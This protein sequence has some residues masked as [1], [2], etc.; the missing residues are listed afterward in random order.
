MGPRR[1]AV[2]ASGGGSNFQAILDAHQRRELELAPVCLVSDRDGIGALA[3]AER[4]GL[5]LA[6]FGRSTWRGEAKAVQDLLSFLREHSVELIAL[7]GFLRMLPAALLAAYPDRILNIHPALLPAFGGKGMYG[8]RVHEAVWHAGCRVSGA[9]V[10]LVNERYDEG[11]I[12]AQQAV[13]LKPTD[14]PEQ[15]AARVLEIEHRLFPAALQM[16]AT[17]EIQIHEQRVT[18]CPRP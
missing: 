10:H 13:E 16:L 1:L 9:T 7:C 3:R 15:I 18:L 17:N 5:P 11:P 4:A 12:L 8:H 2:F 6:V 14:D